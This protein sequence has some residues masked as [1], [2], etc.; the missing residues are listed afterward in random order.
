MG[1]IASIVMSSGPT[2]L[3]SRP[4]R[5]TLKLPLESSLFTTISQRTFDTVSV[6]LIRDQITASLRVICG[7]AVPFSILDELGS[8]L[9]GF[10]ESGAFETTT[11]PRVTFLSG[12][13]PVGSDTVMVI[14]KLP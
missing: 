5:V 6:I 11:V 4:R 2:F 8:I 1:S 3:V 12:T 13:T 9:T 14:G 7:F 10:R